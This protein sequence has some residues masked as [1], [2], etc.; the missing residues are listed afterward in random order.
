MRSARFVAY[1]SESFSVK[2]NNP[3]NNFSKKEPGTGSVLVTMAK[4]K[5]NAD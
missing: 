5:L 2:R 4:K 1:F 3:K